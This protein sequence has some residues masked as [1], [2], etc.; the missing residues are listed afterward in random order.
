M[1]GPPAEYGPALKVITTWV[2][3]KFAGFV[4]PPNV[5]SPVSREYRPVSSIS[6]S[7]LAQSASG[8]G[9][10]SHWYR[11]RDTALPSENSVKDALRTKRRL[12]AESRAGNATPLIE[13]SVYVGTGA[14]GLSQL[15][16]AKTRTARPTRRRF[17]LPTA[18]ILIGMLCL[19]NDLRFCRGRAGAE[20]TPVLHGRR[21]QAL[22]G[23]LR[24]PVNERRL[25]DPRRR[26]GGSHQD[27]EKQTHACPSRCP[28]VR[29]RA[30]AHRAAGIP[31]RGRQG[32]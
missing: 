7:S 5:T 20:D 13:T 17:N 3:S 27:R 26:Q 32:R 16:A 4:S 12:P 22:V 8:G 24:S 23:P 9:E 1:A 30:A 6:R 31:R 11:T 21:Q 19:T 18:T 14:L 29:G 15:T 28:P 10:G 25:S 2:A